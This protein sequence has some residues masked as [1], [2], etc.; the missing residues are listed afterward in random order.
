LCQYP[1]TKILAF[2]LCGWYAASSIAILP[3]SYAFFS[4][5]VGGADEGWRYLSDSNLDWGQDLLTLR[6]WA[7]ANPDRRPI[8]LLY[9]PEMLNFRHLGID[10]VNGGNRVVDGRPAAAG[11]WAV[12]AT[13][14]TDPELK[15]FLDRRTIRLSPTLKLIHVSQDDLAALRH[16]EN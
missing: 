7:N 8:W 1:W 2:V 16:G 15:W 5:A 11:W 13:P 9:S 4:E 12:F 14:M 6:D 10:A 3:R